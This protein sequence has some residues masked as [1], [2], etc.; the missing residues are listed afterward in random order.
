MFSLDSVGY[1]DYQAVGQIYTYFIRGLVDK[2]QCGF[3]AV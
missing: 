2:L 1:E 3:M